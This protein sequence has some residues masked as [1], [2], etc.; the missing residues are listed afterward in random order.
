MCC[1]LTSVAPFWSRKGRR[2]TCMLPLAAGPALGDSWGIGGYRAGA[3]AGSADARDSR[4]GC[5]R[6]GTGA[7]EGCDC[8]RGATGLAC[9]ASAVLRVC[10]M[11]ACRAEA[12]KSSACAC[13][14]AHTAQHALRP[15]MRR[16]AVLVCV[17]LQQGRDWAG[18]QSTC[19]HLAAAADAS[20]SGHKLHVA[21]TQSRHVCRQA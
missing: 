8:S 6:V 11:L 5:A 18:L 2:C 3:C 7:L 21:G 19:M 1:L 20:R 16:L 12:S 17:G 15:C 14:T 10:S 9:S 4:I 13:R